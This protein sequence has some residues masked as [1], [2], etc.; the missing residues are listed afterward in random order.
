MDRESEYLL[1]LLGAY[2][3]QEKPRLDPEADWQKMTELANVHNLAGTLGYMDM[4]WQLCPEPQLR[5][6]LRRAC[7]NT[8]AFFANRAALAEEFSKTLS[9]R[10]IDHIIMKGMV[11]RNFFPV[12]ELRTFGD[13][14]LVIRQEDRARCHC[15]MLELGFQV[16]TD[17]EPVYT[18]TRGPEVYEIHTEIMEVDVS[19]K[20]DFRGYFRNLWDNALQ[21]EVHRYEFTPEYHF[22]YLLTHIAKHVT[23]SGAGIRMYLDLAVFVQ[24]YGSNLDWNCIDKML[25]EL[26]L[27]GFAD[28]ALGLVKDCFGIALPTHRNPLPEQVRADFLEFTVAGGIFGRAAQ[29]EGVHSLE[30]KSRGQGDVSRTGTLVK[31]LFPSAQSIQGRYTYL[32]EKPWLL[33]AAWVHRL[34]RTKGSWQEHT[35][36]AREILAADK[37]AVR[38]LSRLYRD[39]GL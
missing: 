25:K 11:L 20:A 8:I 30:Q 7:L 5:G 15:L 39:I 21:M 2:L 16:K 37:E 38:K 10:G 18:Y 34:V 24:H 13:V 36:E 17:W 23:G 22:V 33:P 1:H 27:E 31:R 26:A 9:E 29:N 28:A 32:Q 4:C 6:Q 14:D 3:R 19:D 35:R 12:P